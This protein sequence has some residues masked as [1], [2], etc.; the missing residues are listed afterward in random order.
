MCWN[1][2]ECDAMCRR[3]LDASKE[4]EDE[5]EDEEKGE[6]RLWIQ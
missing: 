6:R 3:A 1:V 5:D 4:E 2:L